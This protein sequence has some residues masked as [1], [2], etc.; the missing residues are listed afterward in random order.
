MWKRPENEAPAVQ[1]SYT[2]PP[3]APT[4]SPSRSQPAARVESST[5]GP[6]LK[7]EGQVS[8]N[9]DLVVEGRDPNY[10]RA[11]RLKR[12]FVSFD[13]Q[14]WPPKTRVARQLAAAL[15]VALLVATTLAGTA[16]GAGPVVFR[17]DVPSPK[18]YVRPGSS[19][20]S[21]TR[22]GRSGSV[23]ARRSARKRYV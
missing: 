23:I 6:G 13:E 18:W 14:G 22:T 4:P 7:I 3:T 20:R 5:L 19:K 21:S 17:D 1:P 10:V 16:R 15:F 2:P 9:E 8:G 12:L 11:A